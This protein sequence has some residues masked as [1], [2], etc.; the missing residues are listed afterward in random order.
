MDK[1]INDTD[2]GRL[3]REERRESTGLETIS[4][5]VRRERERGDHERWP[6]EC[7]LDD[8][9][10]N[11]VRSGRR[12]AFECIRSVFFARS[13][14]VHFTLRHEHHQRRLGKR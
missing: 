9:L 3:R 7:A 13:L 1:V 4:K 11:V 12:K 6:K 14:F 8:I 2:R 5:H 10:A